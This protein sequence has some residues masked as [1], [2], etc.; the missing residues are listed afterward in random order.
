MTYRFA[1]SALVGL[2]LLGHAGLARAEVTVG[3]FTLDG[4]SF[5]F[6]GDQQ[7]LLPESGSFIRFHFGTPSADGSVPFTIAPA[8]VSITPVALPANGGTLDYTIASPA[9]GTIVPT[10]DGRRISFTATVRAT[11][12]GSHGAGE[13]YDYVMPFSTESAAANDAAGTQSVS[14]TGMRLVEGAW[15]G[16]L[17]GATTNRT[18]AFPEPGAAVYTVLSGQFD[19]IP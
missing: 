11:L 1:L 16:Q 4:L 9:S 12:S 17:V 13:S 8:D 2:G 15:Y 6:F 10:A 7:I 3:T 14:V 19:Q 18:N 5:I